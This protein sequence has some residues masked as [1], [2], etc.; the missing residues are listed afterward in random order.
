MPVE[1][2]SIVRRAM[3]AKELAAD[4]AAMAHDDPVQLRVDLFPYEPHAA[5]VWQLR[6]NLT[7]YDAWYVALAESLGVPLV[8]LHRRVAG[9]RGPQCTFRLPPTP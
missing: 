1:T 5:R 9:S 7:A 6:D 8:T 3:L 4:T 2:A